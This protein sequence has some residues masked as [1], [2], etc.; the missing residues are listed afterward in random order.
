M[1]AEVF[2]ESAEG[3]E[4]FVEEL[5]EAAQCKLQISIWKRI[6]LPSRLYRAAVSLSTELVISLSVAGC[7]DRTLSFPVA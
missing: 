6:V 4:V 7:L 2:V 1:S 3:G 5:V